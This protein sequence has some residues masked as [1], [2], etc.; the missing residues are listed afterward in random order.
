MDPKDF[1]FD[2]DAFDD[3]FSSSSKDG[4][5][6]I[7]SNNNAEALHDDSFAEE[8]EDIFSGKANNSLSDSDYDSFADEYFKQN[9]DV[10]SP[11]ANRYPEEERRA[12]AGRERRPNQNVRRNPYSYNYDKAAQQ[13]A[14]KVSR[15]RFDDDISGEISS[16]AQLKENTARRFSVK[17]FFIILIIAILLIALLI[18]AGG[19]L[20]AKS[21]T[22][23]VDY[24]PLGINEFISSSQ[25]MKKDGVRNILLVGV[26]ARQGESNS[27]TRSD[28][29]MLLTIDDNN[30]Q[31]KLTSFLRDTYIEIPGYKKAKL[32]AS[33]SHGGTQLLMDTLEYNFGI[34]IDNYMLV[35][36]DMF[37]TIIDT[38]GGIDV[39]V[40]EKEAKYLNSQ[41]HMTSKEKEAFPK[42]IKSGMN[43]FTGAQALWYSRIRY[44]DS[45]FMRTQRQRKVMSCV[46]SK[47]KSANPSDL[48]KM[49]D[50]IIPM[51]ETDLSPDD[52]MS[53]G[54][55]SAK[56]VFYDLAQ[57]S[58]PADGTWK[59]GRRSGQSVLLIDLEEN[60]KILSDFVFEKAEI[61]EETKD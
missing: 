58:I 36:F 48:F 53:L 45:D 56:Y 46:L 60:K 21:L 20:F 22:E 6:D 50:E 38:L 1:K 3:I 43:H 15:S 57:Q 8:F 59:S 2:N 14:N 44:L 47:V 13:R 30:K 37:T 31:I 17:K 27:S 29:M 24:K 32:N 35:N 41:D 52:L 51:L 11:R 7:Y 28:T 61:P 9:S 40:T 39:E 55:G 12:S 10:R 49:L 54:M 5:E 18:T 19:F 16:G 42:E 25:L 23:K 4:F 33:Q 26:D 34:D